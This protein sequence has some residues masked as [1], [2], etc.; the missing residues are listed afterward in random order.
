MG[1]HRAIVI[2]I[3]VFILVFLLIFVVVLDARLVDARRM[4]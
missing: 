2:F 3:L 4:A 1:H